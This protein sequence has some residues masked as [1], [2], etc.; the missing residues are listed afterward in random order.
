MNIEATA[1][2]TLPGNTT[3]SVPDVTIG[4]D[5]GGR[6]TLWDFTAFA[7]ERQTLEDAASLLRDNGW[8]AVQ[9]ESGSESAWQESGGR[10]TLR[11]ESI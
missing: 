10:W 5:G 6:Q 2:V 1:Y 9:D 11:V 8:R 7:P 3:G 4:G